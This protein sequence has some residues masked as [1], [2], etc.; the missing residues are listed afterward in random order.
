MGQRNLIKISIPE[1]LVGMKSIKTTLWMFP[2]P[3]LTHHALTSPTAVCIIQK[4]AAAL[5]VPGVPGVSRISVSAYSARARPS[6]RCAEAMAPPTTTNVNSAW[7]PACRRRKLMWQSTAAV[8]KVGNGLWNGV[9]MLTNRPFKW[10][11]Y[12]YQLTCGTVFSHLWI[13]IMVAYATSCMPTG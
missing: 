1:M 5:F 12:L 8:M 11:N 7:P 3:A 10:C 6:P 13:F 4:H 2:F 9:I